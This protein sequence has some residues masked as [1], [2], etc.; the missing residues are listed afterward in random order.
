LIL[1]TFLENN[2]ILF[3]LT[4]NFFPKQKDQFSSALHGRLM[5]L[6]MAVFSTGFDHVFLYESGRG[7]ANDSVYK[8]FHRDPLPVS[9]SG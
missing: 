5:H 3:Y 7:G 4:I 6:P 9:N 8:W 2:L 1:R